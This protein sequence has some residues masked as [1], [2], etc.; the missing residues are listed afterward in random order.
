MASSKTIATVLTL[1]DRMSSKLVT[2]SKNVNNMSKDAQKASRQI[3]T[4]AN[5]FKTKLEEMSSKAINLGGVMTSIL[6]A[7]ALKTGFSEALDLE[8]FRVQLETATKDTQKAGEIM[9]WAID[10]ANKTPFESAPLVEGASKLEMMGM[11]AKKYLP[12]IGDMAASTN[13]PIEQGVEA[14]IDAQAGE[15][16]RLK[17]FGITKLQI[18]KKANEM[19]ANQEVV[20]NKGQIVD[21]EKFN[22]ALMKIMEDRYKGGMEKLSNTT[23]GLWSTITGI[24][25]NSLAQIVGMQQDGTIKTGSILDKVKSK[26]KE[27]GDR[28]QEMQANGTFDKIAEKAT[29]VFT[30]V[31][32][33][34]SNL[35]TFIAN[36][37]E[38]IGFVIS[39]AAGFLIATKA[40]KGFYIVLS[41]L[42]VVWGLFSGALAL[43]PIGWV[44]VG[45]T[46]L[47][48][49]FYLLYTKSETFRNLIGQLWEKLKEL[50]A[51][52]MNWFNTS[53]LPILT[54]IGQN[55]LQLW[56]GVIAPFLAWLAPIFVTV[57]SA[58]GQNIS[59]FFT[60]VGGLIQGGLQIFNGLIEFITGVFTGNWSQAWEGIKEIFSGIWTG[61]KAIA[62]EQLNWI[63]DKVNGLIGMINNIKIPDWIPIVSG[64]SASI[65]SIP[66]FASGT[67]YSPSGLAL[68]NEKGGEIRKL[69][70][71]ETIIPADKSKQLIDKASVGGHTFNINFNGCV[72]EEAFFTKAGNHI[73]KEVKIALGNM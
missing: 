35:V 3:A 56:N 2:V 61:I 68:I 20:N 32:N 71:G 46:A 52:L 53:I 30:T 67:N 21:Q 16:E 57:F 28:L 49:A 70:S 25:K 14:L 43:S 48:G 1:Q 60:M 41:V 62:G 55:L 47:A 12:L 73:I 63:I 44:V 19:F 65:P 50:G 8:G 54:S 27:V 23:K 13:K 15:L 37:K 10:L 58:I 31:Y 5:T 51:N 39:L 59:D 29:T 64:S 26:V 66:K 42:K 7:G 72:G 6:S 24:T 4:M 9:K 69:S 18:A 40:I 38:T 33:V 36:N 22:E 11:S 45:I 17:E 34:I